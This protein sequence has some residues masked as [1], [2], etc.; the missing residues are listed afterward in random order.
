MA[1]LWKHNIEHTK[2]IKW[3]WETNEQNQKDSDGIINHS[4]SSID[5]SEGSIKHSDNK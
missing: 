3:Q 5:N 4:G 2:A 1:E